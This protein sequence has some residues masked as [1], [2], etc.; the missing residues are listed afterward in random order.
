M[1]YSVVPVTILVPGGGV[2]ICVEVLAADSPGP[3]IAR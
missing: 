2:L 1:L 3:R